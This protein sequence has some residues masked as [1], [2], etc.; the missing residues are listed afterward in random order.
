M[1]PFTEEDFQFM[2]HRETR[3]EWRGGDAERFRKLL[4]NDRYGFGAFL[5]KGHFS[6]AKCQTQEMWNLIYGVL[7]NTRRLLDGEIIQLM[8]LLDFYFSKPLRN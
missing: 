7:H 6:V 1:D 4:I 5:K 8:S 2:G 3:T